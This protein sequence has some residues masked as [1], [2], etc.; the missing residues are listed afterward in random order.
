LNDLDSDWKFVF[1]KVCDLF[2]GF[3]LSGSEEKGLH[4]VAAPGLLY[5]SSRQKNCQPTTQKRVFSQDQITP[6]SHSVTRNEDL[7]SASSKSSGTRNPF[8]S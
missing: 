6:N 5:Q 1:E 7:T 3:D 4:G 8:S 2:S